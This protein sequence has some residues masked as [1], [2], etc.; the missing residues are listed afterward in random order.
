MRL[1]MKI[2]IAF[3]VMVFIGETAFSQIIAPIGVTNRASSQLV[4]YYNTTD[5][6]PEGGAL[7][8]FFDFDTKIQVTNTSD[9]EGVWIHVIILRSYDP[10]CG[11][12]AGGLIN[13]PGCEDI[14]D[15]NEVI[16][17][18]R[19]FIDFL[20]P[21]DTH[22][23]DLDADAQFGTDNEF[24]KNVGETATT[25]GDTISIALD[26]SVGVVIITPVVSE[27]DLSAISFQH[28]IGGSK[29][30]SP[31]SFRLNAMGRDAVDY[32]TG[33]FLANGT[34]LDGVTNGYVVIQ[35]EEFLLGFEVF[36]GLDDVN[37]AG[38]NPFD[39]AEI[40]TYVFRDVYG[41]PGLL[42]YQVA[43]GDTSWTPFLYDYKEDPTSCG[44]KNLGCFSLFG[45]NDD[46]NQE[47]L[48]LGEDFLCSGTVIVENPANGVGDTGYI[49]TF[50]SGLD[51]LENHFAV[52]YNDEVHG[53]DY[54]HAKGERTE[55]VLGP[56]PEDC[57]TEGDEDM[58]GAADCA[59][60]DC[61]L[62]EGC[63]SGDQCADGE[64]NDGDG[65]SDCTDGGCNGA[66]GPDGGIC[67]VGAEQSCGDGSDNDGD[68]L[69]DCD[70][71]DCANAENCI[72]VESDGGG[73][74]CSV[75]T[76]TQTSLINLF[77]PLIVVGLFLGIRRKM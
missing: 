9:A 31:N 44:V 45:I 22:V 20:T 54:L 61:D 68:A 48:E 34:V 41:A 35:P 8:I 37:G 75:A 57:A 21:N 13:D 58:D 10:D 12:E 49:K 32:T 71:S 76:T 19:D 7:P 2:L 47:T 51:G 39:N 23:Y 27:S 42:G 59:D 40:A 74:G 18:E 63:E 14:T 64:D 29:D 36:G 65:N 30:I 55:I 52:F 53:A 67:E 16:C 66:V 70:D 26:D 56:V 17:E 69:S 62:A 24:P 4:Y 3:L 33:E 50:V 25:L 72:T 11:G 60:P 1:N 43:Q 73:G 15:G 6:P 5:N 38:N 28:L 46:I 77:L